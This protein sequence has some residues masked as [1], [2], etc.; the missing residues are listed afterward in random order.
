MTFVRRE[1][2]KQKQKSLFL[3]KNDHRPPLFH[4]EKFAGF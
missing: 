4:G 1:K 3:H 2:L